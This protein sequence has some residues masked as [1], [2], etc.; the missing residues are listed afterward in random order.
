MFKTY[1][2]ESCSAEGLAK[3]AFEKI[4][5]SLHELHRGRVKLISVEVMEDSK[6]AAIYCP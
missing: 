6:N 5:P 3:H 2:V 1:A 4:T